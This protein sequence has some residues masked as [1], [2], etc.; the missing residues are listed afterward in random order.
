[1]VSE[2]KVG[3][4]LRCL[5][6]SKRS[7]NVLEIG[8]GTGYGS[9]WILEGM[10]DDSTLDTV[11]NNE[12]AIIVAKN[13][14]GKDLRATFYLVDGNTFLKSCKSEHYDLIFADSWP[15]KYENLNETLRICRKGGMIIF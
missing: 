3:M 7:A 14:L 6:A 8:T 4:L 9:A 1:M 12:E 11:D 10:D 2:P 13:A 5:V 15:G